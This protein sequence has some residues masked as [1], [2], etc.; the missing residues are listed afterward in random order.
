MFAI[1][2]NKTKTGYHEKYKDK[3]LKETT[4]GVRK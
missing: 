4:N 2:A 3:K 1:L